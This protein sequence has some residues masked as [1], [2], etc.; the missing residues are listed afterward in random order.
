MKST[1]VLVLLAAF[2]F[3]AFTSCGD[4]LD[5]TKSFTFEHE[6]VVF[7]SNAESFDE[8]AQ[9]AMTEKES[10][11]NDYGSKIKKIEIEEVRY[12]LKAHNGSGEQ[13]FSSIVLD[14]ANHDGT[15]TK[16]IINIQ[17][18]V[19]ANLLNNPTVLSFNDQGIKKLE[20]LIK[21]PPHNFSLNLSG[22][23]N[24][25]PLDFTVVFQFKVK[26]VAN[27]IN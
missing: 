1:R 2:T 18:L 16:N 13:M 14:V 11:I 22:G 23:A 15:D 27:P 17:D 19:L 12:W 24:E 9:V 6:F 8:A 4:L 25:V 10:L 26:M 20:G 21:S 7:E 3:I 5:V